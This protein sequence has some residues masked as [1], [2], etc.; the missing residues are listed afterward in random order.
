MKGEL[1]KVQTIE[2]SKVKEKIYIEKL[3]NG[4]TV[5]VIPKKEICTKYVIGTTGTLSTTTVKM[6]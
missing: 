6:S 3:E 4:L 1:F 2:S 5:A